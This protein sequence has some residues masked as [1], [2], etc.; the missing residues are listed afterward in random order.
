MDVDLHGPCSTGQET[1][2]GLLA[3][4]TT[5]S[6]PEVSDFPVAR[7]GRVSVLLKKGEELHPG[8]RQQ[9]LLS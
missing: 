8:E 7:I 4:A 5:R 3:L 9:W 6:A 2:Q 1:L